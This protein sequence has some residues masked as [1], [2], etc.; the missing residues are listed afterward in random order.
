LPEP[1][2][3][4]TAFNIRA[5][6]LNVIAVLAVIFTLQWAREVLIPL[7]LAL[8]I[9]YM[10]DPIVAW[11]EKYKIPRP[12]GAAF[13]LIMIVAGVGGAA[14]RLGR[15]AEA[16]LEQLPAAAQKFRESLE[17]GRSDPDGT[18]NKVQKAASEL[19]KAATEATDNASSPRPKQA[20]AKVEVHR[21]ALNIRDYLWVGTVGVFGA[22]MQTLL[23]FF[24]VYFL[25]ISGDTFRRKLVKIA[26]PSFSEKKI[27]VEILDE[28][29][30]QIKRFLLVQLYTTIF[31]GVAIWLAF[32]WIGLENAGM[33]GIVAG[34]LKSIPFLGGAV[35]IGGTALVGYL[36]FGT[37]SMALLVGGVS[38]L[39]KGLE[40][41]LVSP[42]MTSKAGQI[43]TVWV[44]VGILFWGW[45]W[46]VWGLLLGI[47]I[48][49]VAKAI[50]DRID[51]LKSIGE[52]LG[53]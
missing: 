33:W 26:G 37:L 11:L 21:P 40:G 39:L 23:I 4:K 25:L 53:D 36:Q 6:S 15:Q 3:E 1:A 9:Y 19:E 8:F 16:I 24:L 7:V 20:P 43:H 14:Y 50:C 38:I 49:M 42:L 30:M 44:F 34:I 35:I 52:L 47:P 12:F 27:T 45:I 18:L 46:G 51:G 2:G 48:I 31:M 17:E 41:L 10:L 22:A 5:L 13:L 29:D 28:I 32:R